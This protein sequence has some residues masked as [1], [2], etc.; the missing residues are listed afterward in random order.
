MAGCHDEIQMLSERVQTDRRS[1]AD[2]G[3]DGSIVRRIN[4]L[5]EELEAKQAQMHSLAA[6]YGR[7]V[8]TELESTQ[9]PIVS[10]EIA[11][12]LDQIQRHERVR[13]QLQ[14]RIR[15]LE[16]EIEVSEL[17]LLIQQDEERMEHLHQTIAQFNKQLEEVQQS[18][19]HNKE[20]IHDLRTGRDGRQSVSGKLESR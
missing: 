14:Q 10:E 11:R 13:S 9:R 16:S 6:T 2:E 19:D 12:C 18:I 7:L 17:L 3:L 8:R 4:A 15:A 20:R 5:E 1:L